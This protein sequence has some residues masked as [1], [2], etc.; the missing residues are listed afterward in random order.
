MRLPSAPIP[1]RSFRRSDSFRRILV[2]ALA[3]VAVNAGAPALCADP[4][5]GI[6]AHYPSGS[7]PTSVALGEFTGDMFPE[8]VATNFNDGTVSVW[9]NSGDGTFLPQ[10]PYPAGAGAWAVAVGD[11][12]FDNHS[13]LAVANNL[14][15]TVSILLGNGDGTFRPK[16]DVPTGGGPN[17]GP[18]ALELA[19]LNGDGKPDLAIVQANVGTVSVLFGNGIGGFTQGPILPAGITPT[20]LAI[21]DATADGIADIVVA[22]YGTGAIYIYPG[23]GAGTFGAPISLPG[24]GAPLAVKVADLNKDP[25]PDLAVVGYGTGEALVYSGNGAGSFDPRV[26]YTVGRGPYSVSVK[27]L[28]GDSWPDLTLANYLSDDISVL[29]NDTHGAFF[30]Q[31]VFPIG[32]KPSMVVAG[33]VNGDA[34]S[35]LVVAVS[36]SD[37]VA[38]LIN[39][40]PP[41]PSGEPIVTAPA[42]RS[43]L[44][45]QLISFGATAV[46]PDADA[47]ESFTA[48]GTAIA[49]GGSF[50]VTAPDN[51]SGLFQWVPAIGQSGVYSVTLSASSACRPTGVSGAVVCDV[52]TATTA[53]FV[54]TTDQPLVI[55]PIPDLSVA[56]GAVLDVPVH[57]SDADGDPIVLGL[58]APPFASLIAI[59]QGT[60]GVVDATL[61]LTPSS[62]DAG[63]HLGNHIQAVAGPSAAD[64]VFTIEVVSGNQLPV[65]SAPA[66]VATFEGTLVAFAVTA[67]DGDGEHVM[68]GALNRPVGSTFID[69]GDNTGSFSWTPGYAQAGSYGVTFTG[70]DDSG[71]NAAPVTVFITVDN[72]NR[73]PTADPGGPYA[74]IIGVVLAFDGTGSHDV[75]GDPLAYDWDFGDGA[76]ATGP[77]P[78][79]AFGAGGTFVVMLTVSDGSESD[80]AATTATIQDV[81]PA[82]AFTF[83]GN[84]TIRLGSAKPTW[85]AQIEPVDASYL[86]TAVLPATISATWDGNS[87]PVRGDK[88]TLGGDRDANGIQDVT[89]C[90]DKEDL[91]G[92]FASLPKGKQVVTVDLD[93]ALLSGGTFHA[94]LT[95]DV[96]SS[97]PAM[98]ASLSPNPLT[99]DGWLTFSTTRAGWA[100][101]SVFDLHGRLVRRLLDQRGVSPGYHDVRIDGWSERG[102]RLPSG[103]Y[104]YRVE[105][106]EGSLTGRFAI[107]R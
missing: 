59:Q 71:G 20:S 102:S 69:H 50:A 19:E 57:A 38:V 11:L 82:R 26:E 10:V 103:V 99:D 78:E 12:N 77:T 92:L 79:H 58:T 4:L 89:A 8:M 5:F 51:T 21:G 13:D 88:V 27:D 15:G 93:G 55:D 86:N 32:F 66:S 23:S 30:P 61:R 18:W 45:G 34:R 42:S 84:S 44:I 100:R 33:D 40:A 70:R 9:R 83:G 81:F 72:L 106:A 74:G 47:I 80:A 6:A 25:W 101:V 43:G 65:L 24:G 91:R 60:P 64:V 68:L 16:S 104:F 97:G 22:G 14:A 2:G 96:V 76:H 29:L 75:D 37:N 62:S 95:V 67:S 52:G 46:D 28:N 36:G 49:A 105:T 85:C 63:I 17:S 35:D 1:R 94:A 56:V 73:P 48:A 107:A 31:D 53:I 90:F 54:A 98:A 39:G 41:G 87:I 3:L 7:R